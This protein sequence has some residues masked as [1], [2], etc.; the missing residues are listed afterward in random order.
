MAEAKTRRILFDHAP[1]ARLVAG[2][3]NIAAG[4]EGVLP[5]ALAEELA[6]NPHTGVVLLPEPDPDT[7][8]EE[9]NE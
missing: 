5:V 8:P 2:G 6:A 1:P 9:E 3:A 7:E 4:A